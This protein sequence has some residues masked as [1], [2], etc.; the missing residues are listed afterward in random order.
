VI[1]VPKEYPW[2]CAA[3]DCIAS[4]GQTFTTN[5]ID[6]PLPL[7]WRYRRDVMAVVCGKCGQL[8]PVALGAKIDEMKRR[9]G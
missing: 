6:R 2:G 7:G 9:R 4:N 1:S 5:Y 3:C 8:G